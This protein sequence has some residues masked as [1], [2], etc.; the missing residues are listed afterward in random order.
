MF[1]LYY[2]KIS[3]HKYLEDIDLHFV[4]E[5]EVSEPKSYTTL[6][7]GPNGTGKSQILSGIIEIFN[8]LAVIKNNAEYKKPFAFN[9]ILKYFLNDIEYH[10]NCDSKQVN[11]FKNGIASNLYDIDLPTKFLASAISLNDRFPHL[12]EGSKNFNDHY[13]YLGIRSTP[14]SA[15][16]SYHIKKLI[17]GLSDSAK[18]LSTL[19]NIR[20]LF[21]KLN[22]EPS[23]SITYKPGRRFSIKQENEYNIFNVIKSKK[24]FKQYYEDFINEMKSKR[25]DE[26][27]LYKYQRLLNDD[28]KIDNAINFLQKHIHSFHVKYLYQIVIN[29]NIDFRNQSTLQDFAIDADVL[30]TLRELEILTVKDLNLQK[31]KTA[32]SFDKASSGEY[33]LLTAFFGLI[34]KLEDNSIILIDEPEISLH[35]NWQMQYID[36][37]NSVFENFNGCHFIIASHSHFLVSDLKAK[38]SAILSLRRNNANKITSE[39]LSFDTEGWSAENIL[40]TV[41]GLASTRNFYFE[42]DIKTVLSLISNNSDDIIKIKEI[43]NR[44]KLFNI[45]QDDPMA[46]VL[47]DVSNY[48]KAKDE[49]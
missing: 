13:E 30:N 42:K 18:K 23:F 45:L 17:D 2:L 39:N 41:F 11:F 27:R 31:L 29:Y 25:L 47:N 28:S 8:Y 26:R 36:V 40:Y 38:S 37:L 20:I 48:I 1:K 32:F 44:L 15:Y 33:H 22:L 4:N 7:I 19:P 14:N 34:S 6:I 24:A 5:D 10:F 35:P 12:R 9:F 49:A 43:Y 46:I 16:I 21:E 3:K